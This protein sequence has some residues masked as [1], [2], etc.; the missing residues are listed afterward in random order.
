[1]RK[2]PDGACGLFSQMVHLGSGLKK[3]KVK[4]MVIDERA[5]AIIFQ[6]IKSPREICSVCA[7]CQNAQE[8]TKQ[9]H[10]EGAI[11]THGICSACLAKQKGL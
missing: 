7:W 10:K 4:T 1:M 2:K 3:V 11:V 8:L 5:D 9:A 6:A